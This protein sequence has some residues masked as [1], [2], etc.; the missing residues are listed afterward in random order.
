MLI[1]CVIF[2]FWLLLGA[3]GFFPP[4]ATRIG[5]E[6][7]VGAKGVEGVKAVVAKK[8]FPALTVMTLD[9]CTIQDVP[10]NKL[11]QGQGRVLSATQVATQVRPLRHHHNRKRC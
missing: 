1:L 7:V 8:S 3:I 4:L 11:P 10:T 6:P 5:P 9:N 2:C